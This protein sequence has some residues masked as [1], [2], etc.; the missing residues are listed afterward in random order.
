MHVENAV[1]LPLRENGFA[2]VQIVASGGRPEEM[3]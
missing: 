3:R 2:R 1:N